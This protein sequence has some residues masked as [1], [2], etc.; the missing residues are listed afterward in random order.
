MLTRA[1]E[2]LERHWRLAVV[3][4]AVAAL[5]VRLVL[6][7]VTG[8]GGD[9]RG[10]VYFAELVLAGQDPYDAPPGGPV[11]SVYANNPPFL[12][13]LFAARSAGAPA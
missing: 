6:I 3:A 7:A 11:D 4:A 10:Y 13:L 8:G 1:L 5:V 2:R 12:P 9:I